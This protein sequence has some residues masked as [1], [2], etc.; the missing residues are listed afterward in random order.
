MIERASASPTR[1]TVTTAP[2]ASAIPDAG[3]R[4]P[5]TGMNDESVVSRFATSAGTNARPAAAIVERRPP[6]G[7]GP[8]GNLRRGFGGGAP[9]AGRLRRGFGGG[10]PIVRSLQRGFGGGAPIVRS[11][12][13]GF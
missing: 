6:R 7:R 8:R 3:G 4:A 12:Q 10:A 2:S 13:R 5:G 11:L 9:S 1:S